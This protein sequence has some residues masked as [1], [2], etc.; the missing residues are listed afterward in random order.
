MP[1]GETRSSSM[2]AKCRFNVEV[3]CEIMFTY[4]AMESGMVYIKSKTWYTSLGCAV[5]FFTV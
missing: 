1:G 2:W 4:V 3:N 5:L